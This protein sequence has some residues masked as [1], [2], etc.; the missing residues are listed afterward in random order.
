MTQVQHLAVGL[1][2]LHVVHM[3]QLLQPVQVPLNGISS[4]YC[5][6]HTTQLGVICKLAKGVLNPIVYVVDKD[7]KQYQSQDRPLR[8]TTRYWPPPGHGDIDHHSLGAT[9]K[10]I[11]CP[12]NGPPIKS[13][14]LNFGDQ[15]VMWDHVKGLAEVQVDNTACSSLVN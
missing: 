9:F 3:G 12:L 5:I 4:F 6:N 7:I 2:G 1:L 14:S 15:N 8:D 10:P 13:I 11:S